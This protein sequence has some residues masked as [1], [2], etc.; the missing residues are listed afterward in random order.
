VDTNGHFF[1]KL[2]LDGFREN[3][4]LMVVAAA[5]VE[6]RATGIGNAVEPSESNDEPAIC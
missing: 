2:G 3:K 6:A 5:S 4:G 1:V